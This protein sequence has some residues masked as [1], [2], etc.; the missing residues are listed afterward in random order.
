MC[1]RSARSRI[2]VAGPGQVLVAVR[3]A[4]LNP[5]EIAIREGS[6]DARWPA[7]FPSGEGTDLAGVVQAVGRA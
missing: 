5:G 6:L 2:R 4:G 3:A 7:T 1:W